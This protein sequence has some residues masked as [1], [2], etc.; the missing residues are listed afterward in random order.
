MDFNLARILAA[1]NPQPAPAT[2]QP[3]Q[4]SYTQIIGSVLSGKPITDTLRAV[5]KATVIGNPGGLLQRGNIDLNDRPVVNNPD[6][7][8][9]TVRSIT[10]TDAKGHAVLIPTVVGGKVVSNDDAIANW[11]QTGEHLGV[12]GDEATADRYA[13]AL[14]QAQAKR[15]PSAAAGRS[16]QPP[17]YPYHWRPSDGPAMKAMEG[18]TVYPWE[19]DVETY[20]PTAEDRADTRTPVKTNGAGFAWSTEPPDSPLR[21]LARRKLF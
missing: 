4:S 21:R 1:R 18:Q 6:G 3:G 20:L 8:V 5:P 17:T 11:E 14:H 7:S 13:Q 16:P 15:Y 10:V 2:A 12:F 9:S 19:T